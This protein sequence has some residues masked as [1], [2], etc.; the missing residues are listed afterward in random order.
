VGAA[1][2]KRFKLDAMVKKTVEVAHAMFAYAE[3]TGDIVLRERVNYSA[4]DLVKKRDAVVAQIAQGIHDLANGLIANL[5]DYGLVVT[6]VT[7]LQ[8][9]I[10]AYMTVVSAPRNATTVRKG[11]TAE[12]NA[13]VDLVRALFVGG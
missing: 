1:L 12:I 8:G 11:A 7:K 9:V 13:L 10:D 5:A 2:D 3:A 6:D 4:S